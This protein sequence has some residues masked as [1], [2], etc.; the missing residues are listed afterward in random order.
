MPQLLLSRVS[1]RL[2]NR[3]AAVVEYYHRRPAIFSLGPTSALC[4][5]A[6]VLASDRTLTARETSLMDSDY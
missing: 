1:A 6:T 3:C 4:G 5:V 2:H